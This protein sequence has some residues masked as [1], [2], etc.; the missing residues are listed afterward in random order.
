MVQPD[1][2]EVRELVTVTETVAHA[3]ELAEIDT[4]VHVET[5]TDGDALIEF[6]PLEQEEAVDEILVE[7]E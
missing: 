4:E 7:P 3:V 6:V 1:G 2:D 5:V